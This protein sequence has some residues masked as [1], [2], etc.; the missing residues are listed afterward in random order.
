MG[1]RD[2]GTRDN[3]YAFCSEEVSKAGQ[4]EVVSGSIAAEILVF[5]PLRDG[6]REE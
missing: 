2:R 3:V 5:L 4:V 1:L 6:D